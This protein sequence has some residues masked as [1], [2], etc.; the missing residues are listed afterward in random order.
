MGVLWGSI[1]QPLVRAWNWSSVV[2]CCC[3]F[4]E[5]RLNIVRTFPVLNPLEGSEMGCSGFG[6][7]KSIELLSASWPSQWTFHVDNVDT[8]SLVYKGNAKFGQ[9]P[10]SLSIYMAQ[11]WQQ[12]KRNKSI[13]IIHHHTS[14]PE[15][16]QGYHGHLMP[17]PASMWLELRSSCHFSSV[18]SGCPSAVKKLKDSNG[19]LHNWD[20]FVCSS[21]RDASLFKDRVFTSKNDSTHTKLHLAQN[22]TKQKNNKTKQTYQFNDSKCTNLHPRKTVKSISQSKQNTTD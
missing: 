19:L 6:Q 4:L 8:L 16:S 20:S 21:D 7:E 12:S 14:P 15:I 22:Q 10:W 17:F 11:D 2:W 13:Q 18:S 5:L 3:L 9:D 1:V